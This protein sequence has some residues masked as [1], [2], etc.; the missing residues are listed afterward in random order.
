MP[1]AAMALTL[2]ARLP[3]S[4][5]FVKPSYASPAS[6]WF[7]FTNASVGWLLAKEESAYMTCKQPAGKCSWFFLAGHFKPKSLQC[8]D[9]SGVTANTDWFSKSSKH[10]SIFLGHNARGPLS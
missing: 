10:I 3:R 6:K 2:C 9:T 8:E 5:S 4:F 1:I 7:F